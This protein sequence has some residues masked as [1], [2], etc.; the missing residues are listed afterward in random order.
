MLQNGQFLYDPTTQW[1]IQRQ[2]S[3]LPIFGAKMG[4]I[5]NG[6]QSQKV[7][8]FSQSSQNSQI[9]ILRQTT[10]FICLIYAEIKNCMQIPS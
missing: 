2:G 8:I 5:P 6:K 10:L 3:R 4:P 9:T 7:C 1:Q